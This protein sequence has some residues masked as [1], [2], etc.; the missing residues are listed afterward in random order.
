M[1]NVGLGSAGGAVNGTRG[2][3]ARPGDR[4]AVAWQGPNGSDV[5]E[6]L[7]DWRYYVLGQKQGQLPAHLQLSPKPKPKPGRPATQVSKTARGAGQRIAQQRKKTQEQNLCPRALR[8]FSG[9]I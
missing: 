4:L 3:A 2:R 8:C 7:C 6:L 9:G 5:A 1:D